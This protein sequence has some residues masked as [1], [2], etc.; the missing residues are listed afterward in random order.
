MGRT[1]ANTTT[2]TVIT[3]V[4][5]TIRRSSRFTAWGTI[6]TSSTGRAG[7]VPPGNCR[8]VRMRIRPTV[9]A[10]K[11]ERG[12]RPDRQSMNACRAVSM[13]QRNDPTGGGRLSAVPVVTEML[14]DAQLGADVSMHTPPEIA[15]QGVLN[16]LER[17]DG[18]QNGA[19]L[20]IE[21]FL[22]SP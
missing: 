7:T 21:P 1:S 3:T 20:D 22:P 14:K 10:M 5:T 13:A 18:E 17:I 15:G 11:T 16:L 4:A 12:R 8:V 2:R 19:V 9:E 6:V